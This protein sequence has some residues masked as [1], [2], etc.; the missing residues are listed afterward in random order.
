MRFDFLN[1]CIRSESNS[2]GSMELS[3]IRSKVD[4]DRICSSKSAK[5]DKNWGL[6]QGASAYVT[7]PIDQAELIQTLKRLLQ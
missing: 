1:S 4:S 3:R 5:I 7:K 2:N 6:K